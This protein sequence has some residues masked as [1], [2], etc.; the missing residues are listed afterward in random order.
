M[1]KNLRLTLLGLVALL[2][3]SLSACTTPM[4]RPV[5]PEISPQLRAKCQPLPSLKAQAG[6]DVYGAVLQNR[7]ESLL[8][9][10]QCAAKLLG[11]LE[12]V[13]VEALE[14]EQGVDLWAEFEAKLKTFQRGIK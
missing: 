7:Q 4:A 13:G 14:P 8:V 6:S 5:E 9:H 3:M 11:V 12:A 1:L 10:D 2:M